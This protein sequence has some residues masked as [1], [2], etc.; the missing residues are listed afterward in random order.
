MMMPISSCRIS[1]DRSGLDLGSRA[2]EMDDRAVMMRFCRLRACMS[3]IRD[4]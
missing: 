2:S 3:L 1:D 4:S